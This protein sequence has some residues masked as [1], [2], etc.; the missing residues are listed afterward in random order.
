MVIALM[1]HFQ[2]CAQ[3][4]LWDKQPSLTKQFVTSFVPHFSIDKVRFVGLRILPNVSKG[5]L[6]IISH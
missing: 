5:T 3:L 2:H 4:C 6:F 1:A